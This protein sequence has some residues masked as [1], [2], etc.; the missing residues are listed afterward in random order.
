MARWCLRIRRSVVYHADYI[1]FDA[2]YKG[3]ELADL[4][5]GKGWAGHI[6][7][8]ALDFYQFCF[9][10]D[11][12]A[13]VFVVKGAVFEKVYLAV[14]D[15][16]FCQGAFGMGWIPMTS[17]KVSYGFRLVRISSPGR[18]FPKRAMA[19]AWVPH[20]IWGQYQTGFG[21]EG[22]CVYFFQGVAAV[23]VIAIA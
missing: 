6:A 14:G 23:V 18:R 16:V 5:Y 20:A 7:F 11:C 8:G 17:S 4:F 19:R 1:W 22:V 13:D 9:F 15:A 10:V 3:D 21:V 2:F 12:F